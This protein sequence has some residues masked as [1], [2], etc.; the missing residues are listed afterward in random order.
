M[1]GHEKH[2]K[3]RE[4]NK[5]DGSRGT[6]TLGSRK[7]TLL[8]LFVA[9]DLNS[10]HIRTR[11][12]VQSQDHP[13]SRI[14][15]NR[16]QSALSR[17]VWIEELW[18]LIGNLDRDIIAICGRRARFELLEAMATSLPTLA[19]RD[20]MPQCTVA[21]VHS[22]AKR[23]HSEILLFNWRWTGGNQILGRALQDQNG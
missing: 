8:V 18:H 10:R 16:R 13:A 15:S 20:E 2:Q 23:R 5:D 14:L 7:E 17:T 9:S 12:T 21:S 11:S 4:G 6:P 1:D 3:T 22:V 19:I